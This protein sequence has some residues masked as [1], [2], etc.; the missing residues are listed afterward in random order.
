LPNLK[1]DLLS[2]LLG[3]R[4]ISE[5]SHHQPENTRSHFVVELAERRP[6]AVPNALDK[7]L[8]SAGTGLL[9]GNAHLAISRHEFKHRRCPGTEPSL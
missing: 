6:V 3:L 2:D 1:E 7:E 5:Q 9:I 8:L 4:G